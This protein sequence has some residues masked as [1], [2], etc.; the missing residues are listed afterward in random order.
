MIAEYLLWDPLTNLEIEAQMLLIKL[1]LHD[2]VDIFECVSQIESF[3][4][5]FEFVVL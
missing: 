5:Y 4:V 1:E 3:L 2:I